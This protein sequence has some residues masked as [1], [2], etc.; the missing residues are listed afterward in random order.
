[1]SVRQDSQHLILELT[2][3]HETD[4]G[5][6]AS[7]SFPGPNGLGTA[8]ASLPGPNGLGTAA[9]SLPGPNGLGTRLGRRR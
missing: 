4:Y 7:A 5:A 9:A 2:I 6:T 8:A 1:M 3:S